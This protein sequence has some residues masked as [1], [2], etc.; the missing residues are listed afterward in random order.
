MTNKKN[1]QRTGIDRRSFLTKAGALSAAG[2]IAGSSGGWL[3]RPAWASSEGSIKFG[4]ATDMTGPLAGAGI[5]TWQVM[6][7]AAKKINDAGGVNGRPIELYLEDTASNEKVAVGNVGKLINKHEVD[8]VMGGI[9]SSMRAAIKNP[10][11]NRGRT[12]YMYPQLYEGQECTPYLFCTGP[13]PAQQCARLIPH[14]ISQGNKRFAMPGGNFLWPQLLIRYARGLIEANGGEVVLEEFYPIDQLEYSA[15]V[16]K[17]KSEKVDCVFNMIIP[18][19]LQAFSKQLYES[20]FQ[21]GGGS[22]ACVFFDENALSFLPERELENAYSCLDYFQNVDDPV[23]RQLQS[24]YN[25]MFPD[26]PYLFTAGSG[27]TGAYR[28]MKFYEA[29]AL[30]TGGDLDR[31]AISDAMDG[32]EITDAP[33]GGAKM[34]AGTRHCAMNMYVA[35]MK[36]NQFTILDKANMVDPEECVAG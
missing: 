18:P 10:I 20:G 17:I 8:V 21:N 33:G 30:K 36:G 14:L 9:T 16:A 13:T 3:L 2:W 31:E 29:A 7:L 23:S 26:S 11:V 24:E 5:P 19:G 12:L 32:I 27:A 22:F 25:A 15:T 1:I 4:V 28:A 35:Q 34:I 6:Q